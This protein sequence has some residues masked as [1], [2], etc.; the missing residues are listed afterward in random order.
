MKARRYGILGT[1]A[2]GG[3]YGARLQKAGLEVHYL[4]HRDYE[5]VKQHGLVVESVDGDFN[6][7]VVHAYASPEEMP[8]CD[9]IV[10]ALKTTQNELLPELIPPIVQPGGIVLVLQ[11]GLGIEAE[12]AAIAPEAHILGGLCFLCS[13]K[14][15]PGHI[16]HLDYG[17]IVLGEYWAGDVPAGITSRLEQVAEDFRQAGIPIQVEPDLLL[18]RWRKL[19]W[20][21]PYNGLSVVLDAQTDEMM[22]NPMTRSLATHLMQEVVAAA[23]GYG[24]VIP[25]EFIGTMLTHTDNMKPYRT[26]MKIDYDEGRPMEIE[27]MYGNPLRAAQ[28]AGVSTPRI[29]MLYQQLSFLDKM[30]FNVR[31]MG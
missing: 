17:Q 22:A 19:V 31:K 12:V 24:R 9:V 1:G 25:A 18:A 10:V 5:Q 15:G 4:L 16:R 20:N 6:L 27:T 3:F 14:V 11:N 30:R 26:S 21:I 2:L 8:R 28:Q 7:P 29:E 13:N 23:A